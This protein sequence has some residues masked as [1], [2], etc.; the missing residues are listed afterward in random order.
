[1]VRSAPPAAPTAMLFCG[2]FSRGR[3][4]AYDIDLT[5]PAALGLAGETSVVCFDK[6]GTLTGN[7]VSL[8]PRVTQRCCRCC[9]MSG[10]F[11]GVA[12]SHCTESA[13][14]TKSNV[15]NFRIGSTC[16]PDV[17]STSPWCTVSTDMHTCCTSLFL[18]RIPLTSCLPHQMYSLRNT[19]QN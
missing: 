12:L 17:K 1:M 7:L 4:K 9:C 18:H 15:S 10:L 8:L 19:V 13:L 16:C 5:F 11:G 6:T 2:A 14:R 3:L